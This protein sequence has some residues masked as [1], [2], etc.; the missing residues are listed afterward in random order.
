[1]TFIT[2]VAHIGKKITIQIGKISFITHLHVAAWTCHSPYAVWYFLRFFM[3]PILH[4]ERS[5]VKGIALL[6]T[7][8]LAQAL[9][10]EPVHAAL[11]LSIS[12]STRFLGA[13]YKWA[14]WAFHFILF[15]RFDF[16]STIICFPFSKK[17]QQYDICLVILQPV[18][19]INKKIITTCRNKRI[20]SFRKTE[21]LVL[22]NEIMKNII[23]HICC[24]N[25]CLEKQLVI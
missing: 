12:S 25:W 7:P 4:K 24:N 10:T 11:P 6:A 23:A 9:L 21:A 13:G 2:A 15:D 22:V 14:F 18:L 20:S 5:V 16:S 3:Y 19:I 17:I 8:S 1:G